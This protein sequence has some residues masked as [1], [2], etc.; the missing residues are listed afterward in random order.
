MRT[1]IQIQCD[2]ALLQSTYV[3]VKDKD[4]H[5][6]LTYE[7]RYRDFPFIGQVYRVRREVG[8]NCFSLAIKTSEGYWTIDIVD[9]LAYTQLFHIANELLIDQSVG[10]K[11]IFFRVLGEPESTLV[12]SNACS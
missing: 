8:R 6:D 2:I 1:H 10:C 5:T 11:E 7:Y 3:R 9:N 4:Y 12:N